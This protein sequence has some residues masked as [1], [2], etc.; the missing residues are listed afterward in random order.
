MHEIFRPGRTTRDR[1][2]GLRLADGWTQ[3]SQHRALEGQE[4]L[5]R[6]ENEGGCLAPIRN[7][8]TPHR[9]DRSGR[10]CW[11]DEAT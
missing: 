5:E 11:R 10:N 2:V 4:A 6:F 3:A 8:T 1:S 9:Q 7:S